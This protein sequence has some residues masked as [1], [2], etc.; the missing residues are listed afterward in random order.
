[1]LRQGERRE[2]RVRKGAKKNGRTELKIK[3]R[4]KLLFVQFQWELS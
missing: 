1:L 3:I 2:I 4:N